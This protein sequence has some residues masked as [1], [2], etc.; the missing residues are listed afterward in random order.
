MAKSVLRKEWYTIVAPDLFDNER[1]AETPAEEPGLLHGRTVKANLKDLRPSSDKYY[2]D[3]YFQVTDVEG[4]TA[5]TQLVGH[6]T[7]KEYVSR[8]ISR[9]SNRVDVV[10]DVTT[11]DGV[12]VRVKLV[13]ATIRKTKS[14]NVSRLRNRITELVRQRAENSSFDAF[15]ESIFDND[16]QQHL[17]NET[18]TIYPLRDLEIRKTEVQ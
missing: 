11:E 14:A 10:D 4:N 13:A 2:M 16:L 7:A 17:R 18:K 6:D 12:T 8:M 1:I 9:R 5:Q 3:V 15:M